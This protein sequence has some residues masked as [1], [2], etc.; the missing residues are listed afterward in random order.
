MTAL[1]VAIKFNLNKQTKIS[2]CNFL[3]IP[4]FCKTR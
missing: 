1:P 3:P 4:K 2:D